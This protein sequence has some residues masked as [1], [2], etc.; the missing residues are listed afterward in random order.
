MHDIEINIFS[1]GLKF[2]QDEFYLDAITEFQ[3]LID[4]IPDSELADDSQYNIGL[5]YYSMNNFKK[6]IDYFEKVIT[7]YP[8]G[9]ISILDGGN[10]YGKTAAK[11]HYAIVNCCLALGSIDKAKL[12]LDKLNEFNDSYVLN[13]DKK[14]YF[15]ELAKIAIDKF[16]SVNK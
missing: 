12:H 14:I 15:F 16:N 6:A 5:C 8:D 10:E 9:I 4:N 1:Q 2:A 11:C 7:E 3:K 13:D